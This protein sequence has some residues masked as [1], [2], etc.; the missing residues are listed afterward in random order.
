MGHV[1]HG[2]IQDA[3]RLHGARAAAVTLDG[4][5]SNMKRLAKAS[6]HAGRAAEPL[7]L[8][9]ICAATGGRVLAWCPLTSAGAHI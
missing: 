4:W 1:V 6:L 9:I 3:E 2:R 5:A 7:D 8:P